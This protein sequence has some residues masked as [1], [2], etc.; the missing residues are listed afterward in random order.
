ME[1]LQSLVKSDALH[2]TVESRRLLASSTN[3]RPVAA[4][5]DLILAFSVVPRTLA[6]IDVNHPNGNVV[7]APRVAP[8]SRS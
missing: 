5:V 6:F 8:H 2:F 4:S 7:K 1:E 3:P